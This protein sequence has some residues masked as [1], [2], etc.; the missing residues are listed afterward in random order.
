VIIVLVRREVGVNGGRK[1]KQKRQKSINAIKNG[2]ASKCVPAIVIG[3]SLRTPS[4]IKMVSLNVEQR[5]DRSGLGE[6][7]RPPRRN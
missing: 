3:W 7:S 4:E 6:Y 2:G 1:Q 5:I